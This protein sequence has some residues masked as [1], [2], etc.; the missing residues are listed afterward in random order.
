M[1]QGFICENM[2]EKK[3]LLCAEKL[4]PEGGRRQ[5]NMVTAL[6]LSGFAVLVFL[7]T[8]SRIG[9]DIAGRSL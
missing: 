5:R 9:A 3:K 1:Q 8:V 2:E 6:C 7:V 4:S